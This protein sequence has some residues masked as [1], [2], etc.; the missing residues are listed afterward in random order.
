MNKLKSVLVAVIV[1][2][3]SVLGLTFVNLAIAETDSSF[4]I[5]IENPVE[6]TTAMEDIR[7]EF[8][9]ENGFKGIT[10]SFDSID[11]ISY[12]DRQLYL[13]GQPSLTLNSSTDLVRGEINLTDLSLGQHETENFSK[14]SI[15]QPL[16]RSDPI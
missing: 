7:V 6:G 5:F 3:L 8:F 13:Y 10:G 2:M 14:D 11:V 1:V 4:N 16:D 9:L 12:L 15:Y